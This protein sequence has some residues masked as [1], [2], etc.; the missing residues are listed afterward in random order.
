MTSRGQRADQH[1]N[2]VSAR[3][4]KTTDS[5]DRAFDEG[6][7]GH[8][9]TGREGKS[10]ELVDGSEAVEFV[11]CSYLGLE[12]HPA[13]VAA[14]QDALLRFGAHF[15]S[16]RNRMRPMYLGQ[17]E[18]LL[19]EIYGGQPVVPFTSVSNVHLGVL[20]LLG[21]G[22]LPG[23]PVAERGPLFLV[24][25]TAHASMQVLRGVME[26]IGPVRRFDL[27]DPDS[28]AGRLAEAVA[29]GRTPIALVDGVGSMGGLVDVVRFADALRRAGGLLYVDDAHGIS[30][31]GARGAGYAY[32]AFEGGLPDN[33]MLVGSLSKAFGGA[34]GFV[35]LPS[36]DDVRVLRK[37]ANPLVF[38]HSIML[39]LLA[40]DAAA[41]ELHL[42]GEVARLQ[43]RLWA[44]AAHFDKLTEGR[45]VSAGQRSPI[46]GAHFGTEAAAFEAA[47][48][49]RTAG[50][51]VL[52][53]FFPT[54]AKGTGL[55]RF[56]LSATHEVAHLE[57]AVEA[58]G[59][60]EHTP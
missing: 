40:A 28:L 49:L 59:P 29:D 55:I 36:Q 44:N 24:E 10:V 50:I 53:A 8:V 16:S 38:G 2:W 52:P 31:D 7:T 1:A 27:S 19:G 60:I 37:F 14:A 30:I 34:G 48:R 6:L 54:V 11:S 45:L 57:T 5:L 51:L 9:I 39:P 25:K 46:R 13:L 15:S 41:A 47:R 23:Y 42:N 4:D 20:P 56:A 43:E 22:A 21:N 18:E 33:V 32:E 58:L 26:Q 35:V 3:I 17:L 12:Q